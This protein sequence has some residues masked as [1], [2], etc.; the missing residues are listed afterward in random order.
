MPEGDPGYLGLALALRSL[1]EVVNTTSWEE[2]DGPAFEKNI[3]AFWVHPLHKETWYRLLKQPMPLA[4]LAHEVQYLSTPTVAFAVDFLVEIP[5]QDHHRHM[6]ETFL[7]ALDIL[8][9]HLPVE[10][11]ADVLQRKHRLR[12][13]RRARYSLQRN[14]PCMNKQSST[15]LMTSST[16]SPIF[17]RRDA[18]KRHKCSL[19]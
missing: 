15:R 17:K 9:E 8:K 16:C 14:R 3:V 19:R 4:Q 13:M 5:L 11:L 18:R 1:R 7:Y 2:A 6:D 12:A 10:R